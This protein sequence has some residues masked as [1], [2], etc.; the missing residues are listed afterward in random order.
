MFLNGIQVGSLESL[1]L[2]DQEEW[3]GQVAVVPVSPGESQKLELKLYRG[4][5][6]EAYRGLHIFVDVLELDPVG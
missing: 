5:S 6:V 3:E 1:T 4:S 2:G